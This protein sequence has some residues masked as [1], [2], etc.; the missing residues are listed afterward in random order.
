MYIVYSNLE[1]LAF[2][3]Q[4]PKVPGKSTGLPVRVPLAELSKIT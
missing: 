3:A 1:G 2:D 4:A